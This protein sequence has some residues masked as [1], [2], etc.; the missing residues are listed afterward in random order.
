MRVVSRRRK[1]RPTPR[2]ACRPATFA[3]PLSL[4]GIVFDTRENL[5][6]LVIFDFCRSALVA[7]YRFR[8]PHLRSMALFSLP[9]CQVSFSIPRVAQ[10]S[11][12]LILIAGY[13]FRYPAVSG[14]NAEGGREC[15]YSNKEPVQLLLVRQALIM[16]RVVQQSASP[17]LNIFRLGVVR[18]VWQIAFVC[19]GSLLALLVAKRLCL[20]VD[21]RSGVLVSAIW[22]TVGVGIVPIDILDSAFY[23]SP[24]CWCAG[25]AMLVTILVVGGFYLVACGLLLVEIPVIDLCLVDSATHIIKLD[26]PFAPLARLSLA[27]CPRIPNYKSGHNQGHNLG[28]ERYI[29][30]AHRHIDKTYSNYRN[31]EEEGKHPS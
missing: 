4:P 25:L 19:S 26:V 22:A 3:A 27:V 30:S 14:G 20:L 15:R 9:Y 10:P 17:L 24:A 11:L 8:Y 2:A 1:F 23:P 28:P 12:C 6:H 21:I 7:G 13:R 5:A 31:I 16:V 18:C 29:S